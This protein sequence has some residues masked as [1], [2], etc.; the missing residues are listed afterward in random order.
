LY[1]IKIIMDKIINDKTPTNNIFG[2]LCV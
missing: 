2:I 1:A